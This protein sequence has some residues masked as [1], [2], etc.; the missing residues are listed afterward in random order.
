[1]RV[2]LRREKPLILGLTCAHQPTG[3]SIRRTDALVMHRCNKVLHG[4]MQSVLRC[5]LGHATATRQPRDGHVT[6]M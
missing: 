4:L 3:G 2:K 5:E 1:M 6:A